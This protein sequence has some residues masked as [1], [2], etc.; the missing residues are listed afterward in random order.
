MGAEAGRGLVGG[1]DGGGGGVKKNG[2][3]GSAGVGEG[4]V[5]K[6]GGDSVKKGEKIDMQQLEELVKYSNS[7]LNKN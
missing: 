6:K 7:N 4:L 3:T 1:G 5:V 2:I